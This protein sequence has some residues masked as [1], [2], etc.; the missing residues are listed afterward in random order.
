MYKILKYIKKYISNSESSS[1][2]F[3]PYLAVYVDS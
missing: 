1:S 2:R 3:D